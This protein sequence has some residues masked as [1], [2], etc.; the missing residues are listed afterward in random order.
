[1]Q[2][3]ALGVLLVISSS[4]IGQVPA[5]KVGSRAAGIQSPAMNAQPA[6]LSVADEA[7]LKEMIAQH[8]RVRWR[9][10]V[11]FQAELDQLTA[12]VKTR[13]FS[14][15]LQ[16]DLLTSAA[17]IVSIMIAGLTRAEATSLAEYALGGIAAGDVAGVG[18]GSLVRKNLMN[19]TNSMQEMQIR[20]NLQYLQLQSQMQNENRSYTTISNIMKTKHDTV[21]NSIS[22][23]R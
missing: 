16:N 14:A 9:L 22:N 15:P 12:Q 8:Q 17:Q 19:T 1:M 11:E 4:A 23:T 5:A 3:F 10:P 2:L 7:K 18:G 13:L 6:R 20:F 21:K